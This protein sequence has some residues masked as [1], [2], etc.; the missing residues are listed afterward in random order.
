[1]GY[2]TGTTLIHPSNVLKA[3]GLKKGM[4]FA[5]LGAGRLGHFVFPA[6]RIV[7]EHGMV[8]AVDILP[9]VIESLEGLRQLH[10]VHNLQ[11]LWSDFERVGALKIADRSVDLVSFVNVTRVLLDNPVGLDEAKRILNTSGKIL[12]VDWKPDDAVFG[13]PHA[14]KA[15]QEDMVQLLASHGYSDVQYL[16]AGEKHWG[17]LV[18]IS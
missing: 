15:S 3:A 16:E 7:G 5:D 1:M 4:R 18:Q 8:F 9:E 11:V 12:I 10:S 6:T 13:S 2:A 17:L 14:Q